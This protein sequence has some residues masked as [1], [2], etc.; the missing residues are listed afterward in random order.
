[1]QRSWPQRCLMLF[2]T[3]ACLA[4][5]GCVTSVEPGDF[6][7]LRRGMTQRQVRTTLGSPV[8]TGMTPD[9]S[10]TWEYREYR[11]NFAANTREQVGIYMVV[12]QD[13]QL[14]SWGKSE[15][16]TFRHDGRSSVTVHD[17]D[18]WP[19]ILPGP[20]LKPG[21]RRKPGPRHKPRPVPRH[22][23]PIGVLP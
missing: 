18:A 4:G 5:A 6:S 7:R 20:R 15:G 22:K 12:F 9:G 8:S 2:V 17:G 10:V 23:R 14:Y 19:F 21:P 11:Y 13:G 3:A 16:A 1:M